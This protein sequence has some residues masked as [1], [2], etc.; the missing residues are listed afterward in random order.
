MASHTY[1]YPTYMLL[2]DVKKGLESGE[3]FEGN[4]RINHKCNSEAYVPSPVRKY[5]YF[6]YQLLTIFS[7]FIG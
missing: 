7:Y 1:F 2:D 6:L 4:I 5:Y 3:L